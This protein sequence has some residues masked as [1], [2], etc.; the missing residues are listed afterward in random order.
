MTSS[1]ISPYTGRNLRGADFRGADLRGA[2]LAGA[3]L[4]EAFFNKTI[5]A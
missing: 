4:T 3:D 5:G 2:D 1:E